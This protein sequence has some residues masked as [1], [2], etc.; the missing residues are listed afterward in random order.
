MRKSYK[1]FLQLPPKY[2]FV[3][4]KKTSFAHQT[5]SPT[6]NQLQ[7]W[8]YARAQTYLAKLHTGSQP[9]LVLLLAGSSEARAQQL[10]RNF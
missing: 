6:T 3:V 8:L 2:I 10:A 1:L 4:K 7:I 5:A 9:S